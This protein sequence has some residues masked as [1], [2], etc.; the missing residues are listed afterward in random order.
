MNTTDEANHSTQ[1]VYLNRQKRML[2]ELHN[3]RIGALVLNPGPSLVY[4]T[5]LHF[6]LMERPVAAFFTAGKPV[7]LVVPELEAA[8]TNSLP[9]AVNVH[10]YGEDPATWPAVFHRAALEAEIEEPLGVEPTQLRYLELRLIEAA[11]PDLQ[12]VSAEDALAALRMQK[13]EDELSRMRKA[14]E[15]AQRALLDTLPMIRIGVTERQVAAELTQQLLRAGSDSEMP[16]APIVSGGPNSANPHA[17]PSDRPLA[18][19][20]LLVIDWG[21][22]YEGYCSDLTR[23]FAIG[24]VDPEFRLIAETVR[25]ANE[26]GRQAAG[27]GIAAGLV[28]SA[29]RDV[30]EKAGYGVYFRHRTGH[31]LGMQG[32]E[33]PYIRAGNPLVLAPG[34]TF[35]IEPGVYLLGRNGVR[36][37]DNVVITENGSETLSHLPRELITL[38]SND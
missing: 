26:A 32:H 20:D 6:H 11:S 21:A 27:P 14:V 28:D 25:L 12:T 22:Y 7:T 23:T 8:K 36:I 16:F 34:M 13:D 35:T 37:E 10:L 18:S 29:A 17:S 4:L 3:A 24:E 9:F 38:G 2:A 5:G 19:G 1:S 15:I 31:G 33:P 30:I